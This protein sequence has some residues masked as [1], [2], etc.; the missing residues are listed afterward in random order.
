ML[1]FDLG[2]FVLGCLGGLVPDALRLIKGRHEPNLPGYVR[3]ANFWVGLLLLVF[4]GGLASWLLQANTVQSALAYGFGAPEI[5]SRLLATSTQAVDRS[6]ISMR[7]SI[8][9]WWSR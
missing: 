9:N 8:R 2:F 5:L 3:S 1:P 4:L 6:E 7:S